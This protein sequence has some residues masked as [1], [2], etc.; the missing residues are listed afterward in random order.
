MPPELAAPD[1]ATAA[2][3]ARILGWAPDRYRRVR[4]GYT[5]T[6]RY[7]A[8]GSG[9]SAFVKVATTPLTVGMLH[10]EIAAYRAV[11]G[12]FMPTLHGYD[13]DPDIPILIIEDLSAAAW[14][15]PWTPETI[16]QVLAAIGI[17]HAT[18]STLPAGTLLDGREPGW[19]TIARDPR[20]FLSLG[21]VTPG[22]LDA[23]LPPLIEAETSCSLAGEALAHFD[24]RSDNLCIT[25]GGVKFVDWAEARRSSARVDLGFFLPSLAFEGGPPPE[26]ILHDAPDIAALVS[27]FF[28]LRAGLPDIP[29][30]PYVRRVQREQLSAALPWA[31]RALALPPP[32]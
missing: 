32:S 4:G 2:R 14:P 22:W 8:S 17:M 31:I 10:R 19:P 27:G 7:L 9:G 5:P 16:E 21:L 28:A 30:A 13:D 20:P 24:L 3:I 23:A 29:D 6:A 26:T 1:A 12:P 11:S 25:R 18:P 15:P